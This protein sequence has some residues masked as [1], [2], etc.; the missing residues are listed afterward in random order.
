MSEKTAVRTREKW[1]DDVK[2]IAC[3]AGLYICYALG[4]KSREQI[5]KKYRLSREIYN[6]YFFNAYIV[7]STAA[8]AAA[9]NGDQE[10]GST[11][12]SWNEHWIYRTNRCSVDYE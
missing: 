7:C 1:V 6:A 8:V 3:I 5:W 10:R 9:Q 12:S 2:V 11:Y 4:G